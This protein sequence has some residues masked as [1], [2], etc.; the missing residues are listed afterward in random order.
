MD[1]TFATLKHEEYIASL[2]TTHAQSLFGDKYECG[3]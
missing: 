3:T 2:I 1:T